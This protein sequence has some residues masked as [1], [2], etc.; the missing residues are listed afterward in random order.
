[1]KK[2]RRFLNNAKMLLSIILLFVLVIVLLYS[3][4]CFKTKD[5]WYIQMM[6]VMI[7]SAIGCTLYV[8]FKH[9]KW[10]VVEFSFVSL[11]FFA[12]A[13][14]EF[15]LLIGL[16]TY[17]V[18]R[19]KAEKPKR[20]H[21]KGVVIDMKM[22]RK[23]A[24]LVCAH[25]SSR[26]IEETVM[27]MKELKNDIFVVDN[28]S[29]RE[30]GEETQ[31]ICDRHGVNYIG[32]E[33]GN[34][35]IAQLVGVYILMGK[36]YKYVTICDDDL[37]LRDWDREEVLGYFECEKVKCVSY[38]VLP[39]EETN[40]LNKFQMVEYALSSYMRMM[41][42]RISTCFFASGAI[43]TWDIDVI[44]EV[45][46]RHNGEFKG[47]DMRCGMI[48]H[49]LGGQKYMTGV[50]QHKEEY[51][52]KVCNT[53][54]YTKVPECCM[55]G[56]DYVK[57]MSSCEC[58]EPSLYHQRVK[59][60]ELSRYCFLWEYVKGIWK[61]RKLGT[62]VTYVMCIVS[63][64]VDAMTLAGIA[65]AIWAALEK[66]FETSVMVWQMLAV[67]VLTM[68]LCWVMI[69]KNISNVA[70]KWCI[71]MPFTYYLPGI[72]CIKVPSILYAMSLAMIHRAQ[73]RLISTPKEW[74]PFVRKSLED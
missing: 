67:N 35:T 52:I 45:L 62:R 2:S 42:G 13:N 23:H 74:V 32:I 56:T 8:C 58:G 28:G 59:S 11:A 21:E 16:K 49:S 4:C 38:M 64:L 47:D 68:M 72:V 15:L 25:N 6:L 10:W 9:Y 34:K 44:I 1:M 73:P 33:K 36:G 3:M 48:L 26:N 70:L 69:V 50:K 54:V 14:V 37:I 40:A 53:I 17:E 24:F 55:H 7:L 41:Q 65:Y 63:I 19:K 57:S 61:S 31:K 46:V 5:H 60:W 27:S 20:G 71:I 29:N 66:P 39:L 18:Y 22:D 12:I 51:Q 30:E 43:S